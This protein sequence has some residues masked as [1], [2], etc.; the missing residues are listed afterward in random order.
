MRKSLLTK[1]F[2]ILFCV[3]FTAGCGNDSAQDNNFLNPKN[4]EFEPL[5]SSGYYAN[6]KMQPN[7]NFLVRNKLTENQVQNA[8]VV[9]NVEFNEQNKLTKITAMQG[10]TPISVE[11]QDIFNQKFQFSSVTIEYTN[12]QKRY[13]FR[14]SRMAAAPGYYNAYTIGYKIG[15]NEKN[16]PVAYLYDKEGNQSNMGNGYAQMFFTYDSDGNLIKIA[17]AD[18]GGNRVTNT[19]GEYELQIKYDKK[20]NVPVEISNFGKDGSLK[21]A[22]NGI[23]KTIFKLDDK[24]R[25]VEVDHFGSDEM[26]KDKNNVIFELNKSL[27]SVSAA[28]ITR[29]TYDGETDRVKKISFLGKDEQAEGIKDWGNISSLE[30]TYTPEGWISSIS[31]FA[32]D[33]SP[34]PIAKNLFGDNV[35]KLEMERDNFGNLSKMIFYGRENNPVTSANLGAAERRYRY[36]EKRRE[37]GQE[38]YG[39]GGDKIEINDKGFNYHGFT[40][41]YNDDDEITAIIYYD[42][43]AN[44]V[45]RE[46]FNQN[47]NVQPAP[48]PQSAA[49]PDNLNGNISEFV[50]AKN[51]FDREISEIVGDINEY[52]A[53]NSNFTPAQNW[54]LDRAINLENR[55]QNS[56]NGLLNSNSPNEAA[57]IKLLEILSLERE[58]VR[59]LIDGM[60]DSMSGG[61][62][63]AGFK[64]GSD[65]NK[66]FKSANSELD[67]LL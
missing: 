26:L 38:Y 48:V 36:D 10:G 52:L 59:G 34:I 39:T 9:Y 43:N 58:R 53:R 54:L 21:V 42:K 65:A 32:T 62:H 24:G 14:N 66:R 18:D 31:S 25:I 50:S 47:A 56:Y 46:T 3:I 17:F 22:A 1:I 63:R 49:T 35:V 51:Q 7:G 12:N 37:T 2:M 15:D 55:I 27:T 28:A 16:P 19:N 61:N 8:G 29:Y 30:F 5:T 11:W 45:R 57:R 33:D 13:N 41:E 20:F 64:R 40:K 4:L 67:R 44:E 23:A 6:L 60:N